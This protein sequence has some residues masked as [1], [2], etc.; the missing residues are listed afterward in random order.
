MKD[1]LVA[2]MRKDLEYNKYQNQRGEERV[3]N[4]KDELRALERHQETVEGQNR[5]LLSEVENFASQ[6]DTIKNKLDRRT[7][8]N[9]LKETMYH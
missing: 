7:R 9:A 2:E 5:Q 3:N 8:V 1:K 6:D 4:L